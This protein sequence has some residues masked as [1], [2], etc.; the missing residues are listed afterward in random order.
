[1]RY[2]ILFAAL[3]SLLTTPARVR[4]ADPQMLLELAKAKRLREEAKTIT[5][6]TT[7][8]CVV[9][10]KCQCWSAECDCSAC[11]R[12][13]SAKQAGKSSSTAI[14]VARN[15]A[16]NRQQDKGLGSS[17]DTP[18]AGTS[19]NARY[20]LPS[21]SISGGCESGNCPSPSAVRRGFI[22]RR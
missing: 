22:F 11:G 16:I 8:D 14:T 7:C 2:V 20:A 19:T 15:V 3:M 17:E 12:G 10:G 13:G 1:M 6:K 4:G 18:Q 5:V 21:G 9:T